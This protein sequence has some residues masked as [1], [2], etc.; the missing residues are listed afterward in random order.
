[1]PTVGKSVDGFTALTPLPAIGSTLDSGRLTG[2]VEVSATASVP[3]LPKLSDPA[4]DATA[5]SSTSCPTAAV[6]CTGT[7]TTS[8]S[9]RPVGR[10]PILQVVPVAAG[11]AT[12]FGLPIAGA[13]A[14]LAATDT[15]VLAAPTLH[16]KMLNVAWLPGWTC[17]DVAD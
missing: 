4:A 15:F 9:A 12:Y 8:S 11:H 5:V 7:V 17:D 2:P 6:D 16:T 10:L 13:A 3:V 14:T 1:L